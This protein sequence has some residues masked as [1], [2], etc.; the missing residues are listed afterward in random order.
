MV[1]GIFITAVAKDGLTKSGSLAE[2]W[3]GMVS[4]PNIHWMT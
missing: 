4:S 3:P 1:H 2:V